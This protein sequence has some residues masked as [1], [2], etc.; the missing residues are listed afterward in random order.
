MA[1]EIKNIMTVKYSTYNGVKLPVLLKKH[2]KQKFV[3]IYEYSTYIEYFC[4]DFFWPNHQIILENSRLFGGFSFVQMVT[5]GTNRY[6]FICS[7]N[8]SSVCRLTQKQKS[9]IGDWYK[10][11]YFFLSQ[12]S[13]H[14]NPIRRVLNREKGESLLIFK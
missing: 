12:L 3:S 4:I 10:L 7:L 6:K 1:M 14:L 13:F 11:D 2:L 5:R 9:P 8:I